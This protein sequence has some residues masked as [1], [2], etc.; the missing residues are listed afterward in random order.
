MGVR[1]KRLRSLSERAGRALKTWRGHAVTAIGAS[2]IV[3]GPL[4]QAFSDPTSARYAM[5]TVAI[6]LVASL[7]ARAVARG[8][9]HDGLGDPPH[10]APPPRPVEAAT[11]TKRPTRGRRLRERLFP[12]RPQPARPSPPL[13]LSGVDLR[14]ATL[15]GADLAY[16]ELDGALFD[17]A[18]LSSVGLRGASL[19]GADLRRADLRQADL[20]GADLR[21]ADLRSADLRGADLR[22]AALVSGRFKEALY[23]EATAW[24]GAAPKDAVSVEKRRR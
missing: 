14:N 22:C 23:D 1:G 4:P 6:G 5:T 18:N 11:P 7:P 9:R 15:P 17:S 20:R 16:A 19:V 24:P 8:A 21:Q 3:V 12:P 13:A 10:R 2:A